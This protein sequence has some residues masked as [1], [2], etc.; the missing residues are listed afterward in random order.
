MSRTSLSK[1][2]GEH[3]SVKI[4]PNVFISYMKKKCKF[5]SVKFLCFVIPLQDR[6]GPEG[7]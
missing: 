7:V 1:N 6:C 2:Q 5:L 4:F 3:N